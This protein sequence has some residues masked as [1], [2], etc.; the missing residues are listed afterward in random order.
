MKKYLVL[1]LF[2]FTQQIIAQDGEFKVFPNGFIYSEY[3]MSKLSK[4]SDSLNLKFRTCDFNKSFY[5]KTQ[6]VGHFLNLSRGDIKE[7]VKDL[8]NQISLSEFL[9]KYPATKIRRNVLIVKYEYT[10]KDN[11]L[12]LDFTEVNLKGGYGNSI[13]LVNET[14]NLS[15]NIRHKWVYDYSEKSEYWNESVSA[16]YFKKG[17]T[18][19]KLPEQYAK[20]LGY[21]DCMIDTTAVKFKE[22]AVSGYIKMPKKWRK[23]SSKKKMKLLDDL[24]KIKV[25]G[26]CSMDNGPR[27]HA[28]NIAL[29]SAETV[30]WKIFLRSHLDIL[31]DNFERASDGSY[32]WGA[33][34][35]Y[36]KEL[37][38]MN[39]NVKD[40]ILG[41]SL[42]VENPAKN[43]YYGSISRI[44]RAISES[45]ES[46]K[47]SKEI[48]SM[49]RDNELDYYNRVLAY[50]L[51]RN[52]NYY[53]KDKTT[54]QQNSVALK[55]A[56]QTLPEF[57]RSKIDY[58]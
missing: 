47:I 46:R 54:K 30:N 41:I 3:A 29:L 40:L 23:F 8:N 11:E 31:N 35:T 45:K 33:R 24:R 50:F 27:I 56:I 26:T 49:V 43:H 19:K 34:K 21:T 2:V 48:L 4:V 20:M 16:F 51:Y 1:L 38:A 10:N 12:I 32:A 15:E 57:I 39:I 55:K 18:S 52:Y 7:A 5:S 53:Q 25:F 14:P 13:E 6:T 9:K 58:E 36:I 42:R 17:F 44:G 28:L 22:E 37:E